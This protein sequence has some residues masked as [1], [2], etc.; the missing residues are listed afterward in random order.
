MGTQVNLVD[1]VIVANFFSS[2]MRTHFQF[3]IFKL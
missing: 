3:G 1:F 2:G